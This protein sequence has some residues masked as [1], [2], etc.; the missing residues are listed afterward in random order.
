MLSGNKTRYC[1]IFKNVI[2]QYITP[3]LN[4][5][6]RSYMEAEADIFIQTCQIKA[7]RICMS[8]YH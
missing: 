2:F 5:Y 8:K 7:K 4:F 6:E 1:W 3:H